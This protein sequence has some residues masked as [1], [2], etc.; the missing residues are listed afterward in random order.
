MGISSSWLTSSPE[1]WVLWWVQA[2]G[3]GTGS[4]LA[5]NFLLENFPFGENVAFEYQVGGRFRSR[6][7]VQVSGTGLT[8]PCRSSSF[9]KELFSPL[10][11][12]CGEPMCL[13][14][15]C[16][17]WNVQ[18]CLVRALPLLPVSPESPP[19]LHLLFL[20]PALL[21]SSFS[22]PPVLCAAFGMQP[23]A[24][25]SRQGATRCC[26]CSCTQHRPPSSPVMLSWGFGG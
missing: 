7:L 11:V 14:M 24:E 21:V 25:A 15:P 26:G 2:V 18:C 12:L 22:R 6:Q 1:L 13:V 8:Q 17:G 5:M 23:Q 19:T 10:K 3:L 4:A 16:L 20:L 9:G